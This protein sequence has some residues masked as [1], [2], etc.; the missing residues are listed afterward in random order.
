MID[1]ILNL[2]EKHEQWRG[3]ECLNLIPSENIT[4]PAV[5]GLLASDLGHR[6]TARERFYMGTRFIDEIEEYGEKLAR[7]VFEA[8]TAD[9][10]PLSGHIADLI[11]LASFTKPGDTLM[12][13][14]PEDGGYPGLW[15][16][17]LSGLLGLKVFP[18]P[19]S[20]EDMR[21]EV[22]K[23][24][25]AIIRVKPKA[26]IFGASLIL[27]PHPVRELA[28]VAR[29]NGAVVGFDG[30]HVL[31]LIAGKRFQAPLKEGA[32]ALFGST[33]KSLFGPQGGI[34]L[35]DKEHGEVVKAKIY[36]RFVDNAHWN[37]I[38]ALTLA[39][40]EMKS[41]G[42]EY[43]KQVIRNAKALAKALY[44]HGFPV[45]CPKLGF[46]ESHQVIIDF[47]RQ[48]LCRKVAEKLQ[49]ANIIVDCVIR[50]GTCEVTRR[51]MKE[52][53]MA[54]IAELMRRVVLDGENPEAVK[55]DVLK[56]CSEFQTI[57]YC[58]R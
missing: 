41:F 29:E 43:A 39:L 9:L 15:I 50:V 18:I 1:E 37:R 22:E 48:E 58:F 31:G 13:I 21:V 23:A 3:R 14:S 57:G 8:E 56:L 55:R 42:G 25:D 24:R 10:R 11:F 19:F 4:S 34:I 47:G 51:G 54:K 26:L 20:K 7:E 28:D 2:V 45:K 38:A 53:E 40:A 35:A 30:S 16:D 33:H 36:L 44:E 17:G 49:E 46:T 5:R 6:Y 27:F 12:C 52:G 32:N